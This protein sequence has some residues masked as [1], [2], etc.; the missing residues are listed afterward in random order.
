M[1]ST[2]VLV[3][4]VPEF[5]NRTCSHES[6]RAVTV[7][8]SFISRGVG[9]PY[10]VPSAAAVATAAVITREAGGLRELAAFVVPAGPPD[11]PPPG[12]R[13]LTAWLA[14]TLPA[15]MVPAS[16][17]VLA[18]LPSTPNGKVDRTAL[19]RIRPTASVT[20]EPGGSAATDDS[21]TAEDFVAPRDEIEGAVAA[22]WA[23][24]LGR[25]RIDVRDNFFAVGG[26]SLLATQAVSRLQ[27]EFGTADR[28]S[29]RTLFEAP[30][31]ERFAAAIVDSLMAG[32][33]PE[34]LDRLLAG[35]GTEP[36]EPA[37]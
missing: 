21:P 22:V 23:E 26:H 15:Y 27:A 30:T 20:E 7:S 9:A 29:L 25:L 16:I 24:L 31:V 36:D 13:A 10:D 19:T 4:S 34:Q 37:P 28:L 33:D 3:A 35:H 5:M 32:M 2:A 17:T 11:A 12:E 1:S 18:E 8:A 6:T 14:A